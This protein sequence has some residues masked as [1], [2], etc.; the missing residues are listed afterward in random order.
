MKR[1]AIDGKVGT[2]HRSLRR[3]SKD[4]GFLHA[5]VLTATTGGL[6]D[7]LT[8]EIL[9]RGINVIA[10]GQTASQLNYLE[11]S[12][13]QRL[14]KLELDVTSTLSIAA[15]VKETSNMTGG[16]LSIL[17][18]NAGYGYMTPLM[19]VDIEKVKANYDVNVFGLLAVTQAFFPLLRAGSATVVNQT[20]IAGLQGLSQP[21]IGTYSSSKAAVIGLSDTMRVELAPFDV[22]VVA[23]VTGDV[24]TEFWSNVQGAHQ[25]I[26]E[27]SA[28]LQIKD[29][30]DA[31]MAGR[32]NPPGQH[33]REK[34]A[35]YVVDD[36]LKANPPLYVRKGYLAT[37]MAWVTWLF[38]TW[39]FDLTFAQTSQSAKLK[40]LLRS[41]EDKKDL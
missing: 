2:H 13:S 16:R 37:T 15:A 3:Y 39:L 11:T 18:N 32:T 22:K 29:H 17:I 30:V 1:Y 6:G 7:A 23:L 9:T 24:K 36:L 41:Q 34:W 40:A 21:F 26:P 31:M 33:L 14:E 28:Y 38:P 5:H 35:K 25:G 27:T 8:N 19:D 20:S 10:T 12:G 4:E